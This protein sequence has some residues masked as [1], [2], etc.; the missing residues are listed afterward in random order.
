LMRFFACPLGMIFGTLCMVL[1]G[2]LV[3]EFDVVAR[4]LGG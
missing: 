2:S 1:S 3:E 4:R